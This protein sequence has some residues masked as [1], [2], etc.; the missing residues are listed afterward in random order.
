MTFRIFDAQTGGNQVFSESQSVIVSTGIFN[1]LIGAATSGGIPLSVFDGT[2]RYIEVQ[3]GAQTLPRQRI[4]SVAYTFKSQNAGFADQSSTAAYAQ[5]AGSVVGSA[6]TINVATVTASALSVTT[7]SVSN[8]EIATG[9]IQITSGGMKIGHSII[10]GPVNGTL[11]AVNTIAFE[12]G[13]GYITTVNPG[14]G[15]LNLVTANS[16]PI[17]MTGGNVGVGTTNPETA[18]HVAAGMITSGAAGATAGGV[19]MYSV[20]NAFATAIVANTAPTAAITYKLPPTDGLPGQV[21]ATDGS[22]NLYWRSVAPPAA[23]SITSVS[24]NSGPTS[25]GTAIAIT[26]ANFQN[27]AAVTVGG[28]AATGVS[29]VGPT[30]L[31][32][33]T[34]AGTAGAK[35]I[36]VTNPDGQSATF[37][38]G[39]AYAA[40]TVGPFVGRTTTLYNGNL[41]GSAGADAKC[42]AQYPGSHWCTPTDLQNAAA[43][44]GSSFS[45]S[46][47]WSAA[48]PLTTCGFG[49]CDCPRSD[50]A[51]TWCQSGSTAL[52]CTDS[53][54][55]GAYQFSATGGTPQ[56]NCS[57][58]LP[59]NCCQ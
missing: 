29:F 25:G 10:L 12:N 54:A 8:I 56:A 51:H 28:I 33:T 53:V 1:V 6:A 32:A 20:A 57:T 15:S 21:L 7:M 30:Q 27:G 11:G 46:N 58:P 45:L 35:N 2:D 50:L 3:V 43:A 37:A 9:T 18:L 42:A 23:P 41:G 13:N 16:N 40:P 4:V 52:G 24:P 39:F 31:N 36:V 26:G 48:A 44:G 14:A 22:G 19:R 59:L 38:N 55:N 47:S 34:P 5:I 17:T 49:A